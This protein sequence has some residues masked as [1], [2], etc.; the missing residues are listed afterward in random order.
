MHINV[1]H[2]RMKKF[3]CKHCK[4]TSTIDLDLKTHIAECH[5]HTTVMIHHDGDNMLEYAIKV[6]DNNKTE[7]NVCNRNKRKRRFKRKIL[8]T[9][10]LVQNYSSFPLTEGEISLMNRG[11]SFVPLPKINKTEINSC[12]LKMD[13]KIRLKWHHYQTDKD[14]GLEEYEDEP[15]INPIK[16]PPARIN[17]STLKPPPEPLIAF[18]HSVKGEITTSDTQKL[19]MNL[20]HEERKGMQSLLN[21]QKDHLIVV[22]RCDKTGGFAVMDRIDYTN[23]LNKMLSSKVCM[24][25]DS[26][27]IRE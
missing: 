25:D 9:E 23:S 26:E 24:S 13:R 27:E 3:K 16:L 12:L 18:L 6:I 22:A 10:N 5:G 1:V 21:K 2:N 4:F 7:S 20:T 14:L 19:H 11:R 17:L 15:Y 8:V